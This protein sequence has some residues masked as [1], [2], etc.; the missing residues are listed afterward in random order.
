M[1]SWHESGTLDTTLRLALAFLLV[2]PLAWERER[3]P[4]AAGLR[5]YP[6]L[7]ACICGVMLLAGQAHPGADMQ[8]FA[9]QGVLTGIGFVASGA[10]MKSPDGVHGMRTA[11]TLWV[12]GAVGVGVAHRISEISAVLS[13]TSALAL[14]APQPT[15]GR[16][17]S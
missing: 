16:R 11:V 17:P 14:W 13:L 8:S 12:T 7:S 6:L 10:I 2:L 5:T 1:T 9:F 3:R 15:S 4:H